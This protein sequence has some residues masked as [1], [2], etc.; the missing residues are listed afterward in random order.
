MLAT[1]TLSLTAFPSFPL[2]G[3]QLTC[4]TLSLMVPTLRLM[5]AF[6]WQVVQHCNVMHYGKVEEL[7]Q[8]VTEVVP[9][10]LSDREKVDLFVGLKATV[11]WTLVGDQW[12]PTFSSYVTP[13]IRTR[14]SHVK[15]FQ[16]LN[17]QIKGT[18]LWAGEIKRRQ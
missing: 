16:H 10:L 18:S 13:G 8:L 12:F 1:L 9:H 14:V 3:G 11:R 4:S 17:H 6:A 15:V 2:T 7:V 5:S